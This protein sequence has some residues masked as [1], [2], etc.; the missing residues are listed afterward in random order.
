V[1]VMVGKPSGLGAVVTVLIGAA[2][3]I[4]SAIPFTKP[5]AVAA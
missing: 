4:V 1:F 5:A 3:G 2:V